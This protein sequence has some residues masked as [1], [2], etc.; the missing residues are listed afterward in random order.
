[1]RVCIADDSS[2]LDERLVAMLAE[3]Q[4]IEIT[5]HAADVR[6]ANR[7]IRDLKPHVVILD[8]NMPEGNGIEVLRNIKREIPMTI[9]VI[10]TIY[11]HPQYQKR[12]LEARADSLLDN[13]NCT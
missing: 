9:V 4:E 5:G 2:L 6:T 11:A 10:L 13:W 3:Y 7:S 8:L 1:M 12:C